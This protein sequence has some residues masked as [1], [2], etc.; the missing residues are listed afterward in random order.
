MYLP[1]LQKHPHA[2][3]TAICGRNHKRTKAFAERWQ[4]PRYYTDV[5]QMLGDEALEAII[6]A[7]PND[8]HYAI[9]MQVLQRGYI[10]YVK[11][12]WHSP[13]PKLRKWPP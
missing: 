9:G 3:V 7:T 2:R 6:I 10:Y 5:A 11:N 1:A 12:H 13:I 8:S 4:I